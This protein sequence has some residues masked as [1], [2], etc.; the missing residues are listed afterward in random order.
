MFQGKVQHQSVL[1]AVLRDV[2]HVRAPV[3]D[4]GVADITAAKGHRAAA[5]LLQAGQAV[6]ELA[7]A[8]AVDAGDAQNLTRPGL[9]AD[10]MDRIPLLGMGGDRQVLHLEHR[11]TGSGLLL[12]HL[13]L[14][15]AA[16]HHVGQGLLVGVLSIHGADVLALAQHCDA[17]GHGHNLVELVGDE[18]NT[19]A[20][21]G[22]LLHGGHQLINL[23]GGEDGGGL[24][25][26]QNLVVAVEH[27][28]DLHPLLHAH[29][30][31]FH[32]GVQIHL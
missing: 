2:A 25:K 21:L 7:L 11:L 1:M 29:G 12:D 28:E 19:L 23:L 17:V 20:L 18:E 6:D 30:D 31:V 27:L 16:H 9:E 3:V 5:A 24:V 15:R 8:V 26:D 22:K 32:P 14:H 4:G 13:K 10:I